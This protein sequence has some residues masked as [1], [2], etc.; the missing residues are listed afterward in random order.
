[1][2]Y[3]LFTLTQPP[4]QQAGYASFTIGEL[5]VPAAIASEPGRTVGSHLCGDRWLGFSPDGGR[6]SNGVLPY[7]Q[8]LGTSASA[9]YSVGW[10]GNWAANLSW[11]ANTT[12]DRGMFNAKISHTAY[13]G[14]TAEN[15]SDTFCSVLH[16]G[17]SVRSMRILEIR[18]SVSEAYS[19]TSAAADGG[20]TIDRDATAA[21]F[22]EQTGFNKHR[23]VV[24][25]YKAPRNPRTPF[26]HGRSRKMPMVN[27]EDCDR[28]KGSIRKLSMRHVARYLQIRGRP[29]DRR[30][31]APRSL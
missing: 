28:Y 29:I 21:V 16:A 18:T 5:C 25:N 11:S 14:P 30:R 15:V 31:H 1:M 6:S 27:A 26:T 17:E 12:A 20:V 10:S 23:S 22:D 13:I 9:V 2:C 19:N 3:L 24:L 7:F 8:L 4:L